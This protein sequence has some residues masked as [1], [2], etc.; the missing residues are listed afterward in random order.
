MSLPDLNSI[1]A[2]LLERVK[3][4]KLRRIWASA[5]MSVLLL[6]VSI[7]FLLI[8]APGDFPVNTIITIEAKTGLND[9]TNK[10][11]DLKII[12]SPFWFR[13]AV[14]VM[15]GER[16][17][18]AGDYYFDK[19]VSVFNVASRMIG[20]NS[21]LS[22]VKVTLPE[23]LTGDQMS[24][25]LEGQLINFDTKEFAKIAKLNEGYLFPDTYMLAK[26]AKPA[27]VVQ[28]MKSNFDQKIKSVNDKIVAFKK[29]IKDVII[30]DSILEAE[31]RTTETRQTI[32]G[33]LWKR[34]AMGIPLQVDAPFQYIIGKNTFQ[35]TTEDLK[36][37]SPYNTY[38][39][40]GLPP[41]A[42]G[43]PGLDAITATVTPISTPYLFYLS[44]IRG[45]MH[46]AKTYAEHLKNKELYLK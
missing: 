33:I 24:L 1:N 25:V 42:I 18:M 27:D 46:Y 30:M 16:G 21:G 22:P 31:A 41:T 11:H 38:K 2:A 13:I 43:N 4:Q 37:D 19:P 36:F 45:G 23:G 39:Y 14:I 7:Y 12:R 17:V 9:V 40:K 35:L 26:N 3:N 5:F 6:S 20:G 15:S 34:L 44:D 10:L 28:I 29:P 8:K 32:A